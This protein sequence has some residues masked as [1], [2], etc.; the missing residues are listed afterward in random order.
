M[1][2]LGA[3][4]SKRPRTLT[5]CQIDIEPTK[6]KSNTSMDRLSFD[7]TS[8]LLELCEETIIS[9]QLFCQTEMII[10]LHSCCGNTVAN[11]TNH[12][13]CSTRH[14]GHAVEPGRFCLPRPA[15]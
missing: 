12:S 14:Q 6:G 15:H 1:Y 11:L 9:G 10:G 2:K 4:I 8:M 5:I 13:P 7:R 3:S